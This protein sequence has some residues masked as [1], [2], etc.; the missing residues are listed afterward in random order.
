MNGSHQTSRVLGAAFLF[1]AMTSLASGLILQQ[2]LTVPGDIRETMI[3]IANHAWLMRAN[4]FGESIT[5]LGIIFLGAILFT[6]LR[7]QEEKIALAALGFYIL[8]AALLAASRI[9]AFSLLRISQEYVSTGQPA[10]LQTL[11]NLAFESTKD[12]YTLLMLPCCLGLMAFYSLLYKSRVV[13]RA[14][15]LWGLIAT[16]PMLV[17]TVAQIFG[18][19]IP[20]I[21]YLP[22]V[23]F[24]FFVGA[25]ILV[26]GIPR[27]AQT[28]TLHEEMAR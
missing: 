23:P 4:I 22:Y 20:F 5:A 14:L 16:F 7:K 2:V 12:G 15:S 28:N 21:F 17:G 8:E 27:N 1:Q 18:H 9:P 24:E 19:A 3:R 6:T 13:P 26:K 25:W 10:Y 11:G